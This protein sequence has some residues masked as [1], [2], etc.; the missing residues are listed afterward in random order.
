MRLSTRIALTVTIAGT[1]AVGPVASA[2]AGITH[3]PFGKT[4]MHK[5]TPRGAV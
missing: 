4:N 2:E 5:S 3:T 1:L